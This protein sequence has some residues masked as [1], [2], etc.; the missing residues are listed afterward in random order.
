MGVI[1]FWTNSEEQYLTKAMRESIALDDICRSIPRHSK[2][3]VIVRAGILRKRHEIENNFVNTR[4][5]QIVGKKFGERTVRAAEV[6]NRRTILTVECKC[7]TISTVRRETL[8]SGMNQSCIPCAGKA[9]AKRARD[10][11]PPGSMV[12]FWTMLGFVRR[13]TGNRAI[14]MAMCGKCGNKKKTHLSTFQR[15]ACACWKQRGQQPHIIAAR[16]PAAYLDTQAPSPP[17]EAPLD[18]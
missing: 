15:T 14:Y 1:N 4:V 17:K 5:S 11:Y 2:E 9:A 8:V 13:G 6:V 3:A 18:P 16:V 7:G 10:K 12:G